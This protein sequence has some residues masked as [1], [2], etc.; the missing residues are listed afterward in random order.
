MISGF[1]V[2]W[3]KTKKQYLFQCLLKKN[4]NRK[5]RKKRGKI[6]KKMSQLKYSKLIQPGLL[7]IQVCNNRGIQKPEFWSNVSV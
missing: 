5:E 4:K 6:K 2:E 1:R 7:Y 3:G